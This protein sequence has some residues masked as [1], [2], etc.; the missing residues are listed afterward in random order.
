LSPAKYILH[1]PSGGRGIGIGTVGADNYIKC[2]W[3]LDLQKGF[4]IDDKLDFSSVTTQE[5]FQQSIG[6]PFLPTAG[7]TVTG[8][9]KL[10][11]DTNK[12]SKA[13]ITAGSQT[14]L[15][16]KYSSYENGTLIATH[17]AP[18]AI[19]GS[20]LKYLKEISE[21]SFV[22]YDILHSGNYTNYDLQV[23]SI[24]P[25][26][27]SEFQVYS[28]DNDTSYYPPKGVCFKKYGKMIEVY[29]AITPKNN[30][31]GSTVEY[32][33]CEIPA[34]HIPEYIITR[35]CQGSNGT[36]WL[37]RVRPKDSTGPARLTFSR[38]GISRYNDS[39]DYF[40]AETGS[41]L[42]FHETWLIA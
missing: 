10:A 5:G 9:I 1:I 27:G 24:S 38:Y 6:G 21:N 15:A 34:G 20:E 13:R 17:T 28:N 3:T 29:G 32:T 14:L 8:E 16:Y 12:T 4:K 33:I 7:G 30:I 37:L 26:L 40:E 41:W 31:S 19:R 22:A 18:T 42:T 2:G 39:R 36:K 35:V 11:Y 23:T 25:T